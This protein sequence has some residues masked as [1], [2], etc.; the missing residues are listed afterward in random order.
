MSRSE[1]VAPAQS[2]E[3]LN[4]VSTPVLNTLRQVAEF[5]PPGPVSEL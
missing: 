1:F 5:V 2:C 3:A 4:E